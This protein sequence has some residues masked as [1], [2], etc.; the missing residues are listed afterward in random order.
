M[1]MT[2]DLEADRGRRD[3]ET[4]AGTVEILSVSLWSPRFP[5][6]YPCAN[7][8]TYLGARSA[9]RRHDGGWG[10]PHTEKLRSLILWRLSRV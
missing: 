9:L 4:V 10:D 3:D 5:C 6:S 8:Q 2:N 1:G 7:A